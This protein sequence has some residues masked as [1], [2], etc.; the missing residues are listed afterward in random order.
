MIKKIMLVAVVFLIFPLVTAAQPLQLTI[1][2]EEEW[3][4]ISVP[5]IFRYFNVNDCQ[6]DLVVDYDVNKPDK[7]VISDINPMNDFKKLKIAL[8]D[9]TQGYFVHNKGSDCSITFNGEKSTYSGNILPGWNL[10]TGAVKFDR[11]CILH[12]KTY[13]D[14]SLEPKDLKKLYREGLDPTKGYWIYVE[15]NNCKIESIDM[16]ES[17]LD[18]TTKLYGEKIRVLVIEFEGKDQHNHGELCCQA[19]N[20]KCWSTFGKQSCNSGEIS[21]S[22]VDLL[23]NKEKYVDVQISSGAGQYPKRLHSIFYIN[24]YLKREAERYGKT[25]DQDIFDITISGPHRLN[26]DPPKRSRSGVGEDLGNFFEFFDNELINRKINTEGYDEIVFI[27][28][29][30]YHDVSL[31]PGFLSFASFPK[32]YISLISQAYDDNA[33]DTFLHE[34][35]HNLAIFTGLPSVRDKYIA[36]CPRGPYM[37]CSVLP[38]GIPEP[39]KVP[40]FPQSKACIMGDGVE[41]AENG[42]GRIWRDLN[43][44]IICSKTAEELGWINGKDS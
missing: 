9:P 8:D 13:F 12:D 43:E 34:N 25:F 39:N 27:Y 1:P 7:W 19:N 20:E 4:L 32:L 2:I 37:S 3:S 30:D 40:L 38:I 15:N 33:L 36:P 24:D 31:Y 42:E 23:N 28:L 6:I 10:L 17:A 18:K 16:P 41:L 21:Y 22:F 11:N 14:G 35:I 5:M 29:H 26:A 44:L